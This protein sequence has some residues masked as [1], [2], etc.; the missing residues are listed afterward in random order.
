MVRRRIHH[1]KLLILQ[2]RVV[3]VRV[4][5]FSGHAYCDL[6]L[7]KHAVNLWAQS[8][9]SVYFSSLSRLAPLKPATLLLTFMSPLKTLVYDLV[10][11]IV[12]TMQSSITSHQSITRTSQSPSTTQFHSCSM[13]DPIYAQRD[14]SASP[15]KKSTRAPSA[16]RTAQSTSSRCT[17]QK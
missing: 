2:D 16:I 9:Q 11:W 10:G 4:K 8:K 1:F 5:S 17:S 15:S 7:M 12:L 13:L 14:N 6:N 3:M